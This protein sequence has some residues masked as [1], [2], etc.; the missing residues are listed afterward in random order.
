M[1]EKVV[2][3]V[4]TEAPIRAPLFKEAA[5]DANANIIQLDVDRFDAIAIIHN[6]LRAWLR[7]FL[8][9]LVPER[10]ILAVALVPRARVVMLAEVLAVTGC[11]TSSLIESAVDLKVYESSRIT[12]TITNPTSGLMLVI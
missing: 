5:K 9:P 7:A 10:E 4:T 11:T 1:L 2:A 3:V 12:C 6:A 8:H